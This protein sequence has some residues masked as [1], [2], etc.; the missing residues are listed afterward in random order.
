MATRPEVGSARAWRVHY[1]DVDRQVLA[2]DQDD[3]PARNGGA[4]ASASAGMP[5]T[6]SA[7]CFTPE[8]IAREAAAVTA[9][10]IV[11]MGE[12]GVVADPKGSLGLACQPRRRNCPICRRTSHEHNFAGTLEL[13]WKRTDTWAEWVHVVKEAAAPTRW[14]GPT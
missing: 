9:P 14:G 6:V 10:V 12:R 8:E 1:S 4:P 2:A 11:A 7:W 3:S 13:L 5:F